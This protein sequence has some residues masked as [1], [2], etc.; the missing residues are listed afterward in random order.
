MKTILISFLLS[1]LAVGYIGC[2]DDDQTL[3]EERDELINQLVNIS[4]TP[5]SVMREGSDVIDDFSTFSLNI[6]EGTYSSQN[7]KNVWPESGTWTFVEG[8]SSQFLRD[9]DVVLDVSISGT[10]LTMSFS[11]DEN[12]FSGRS[13]IVDASY[14]FVLQ[15]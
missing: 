2:K 15:P 8:S 7:G 5:S 10:T 3:D 12:V 14:I 11:I 4:W 1:L 9:D 6:G 13:K